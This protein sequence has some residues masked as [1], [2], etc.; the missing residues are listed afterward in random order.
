MK[1]G[2][3]EKVEQALSKVEPIVE[4]AELLEL[5]N[6]TVTVVMQ[7]QQQEGTN[8]FQPTKGQ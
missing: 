6:N 4:E 2:S 1:I 3:T 5:E 7:Y 8:S